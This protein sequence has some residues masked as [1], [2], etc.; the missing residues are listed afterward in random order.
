MLRKLFSLSIF[1]IL[2]IQ[3]T[4]S[5]KQT[6]TVQSKHSPKLAATLSA[7]MPGLGQAYNKKYW[8]IPIIY[9]GMGTL[10]YLTYRN[11][12]YYQDFRT[13]YKELSSTNP[14]GYYTMYNTT[15]TL[16]G[17]DAGKNYYRRYRDMF[18]IFTVGVYFLNIIDATVDAYLFD[19]DI[20][21]KL[22]L[23]IHPSFTPIPSSCTIEPELKIC[24]NF[25]K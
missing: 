15:F 3:T 25:K 5:Q 6:D 22:S 11:N 16:S 24:L 9:G 8:K 18:A 2:F 17:L 14:N 12:K 21:D 1:T 20:S 4:V 23:Q 13:A 19:F 10:A 7:I